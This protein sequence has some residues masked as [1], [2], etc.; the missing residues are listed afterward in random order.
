MI[1]TNFNNITILCFCL[2]TGTPKF[3]FEKWNMS[4]DIWLKYTHILHLIQSCLPL[5]TVEYCTYYRHQTLFQTILGRGGL[6]VFRNRHRVLTHQLIF[7]TLRMCIK[8]K[9]VQ[10]QIYYFSFRYLILT[11]FLPKDSSFCL[12]Y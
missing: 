2:V 9:R 3:W 6:S 11:F 8:V 5:W 7:S 12:S 1:R 10:E 4:F